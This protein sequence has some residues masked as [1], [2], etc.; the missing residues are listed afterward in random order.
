VSIVALWDD[1]A[2]DR[3]PHTGWARDFWNRLCP[4]AAGSYVNSL[5]DE[6]ADRVRA[7]YG[8][9]RYDRLAAITSTYDPTNF[10]RLNHNIAPHS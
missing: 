1:P 3:A 7:A 2:A 6:G 9:A 8:A 5:G 4:H 10:F